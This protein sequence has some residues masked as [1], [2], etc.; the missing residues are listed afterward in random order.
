MLYNVEMKVRKNKILQVS[1]IH[2]TLL[3]AGSLLVTV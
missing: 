1:C 3:D 2:V